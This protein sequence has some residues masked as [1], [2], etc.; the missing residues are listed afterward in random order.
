MALPEPTAVALQLPADVGPPASVRRTVGEIASALKEAN[1]KKVREGLAP[2]PTHLRAVI[3]RAH[4]TRLALL[5]E[6]DKWSRGHAS[7]TGVGFFAVKLD[8]WRF[9]AKNRGYGGYLRCRVKGCSWHLKI[10]QAEDDSICVYD[11]QLV[12]S[13]GGHNPLEATRAEVAATPGFNH[14]PE[15]LRTIAEL[16]H[17]AGCNPRKV[18][19]M[20]DVAAAGSGIIK[21]WD[22]A[23]VYNH[24]RVIDGPKDMDARGLVD[25]LN[26]REKRH[27]LRYDIFTDADNA[28]ERVFF[29]VPGALE[30]QQRNFNVVL[31]DTT[32]GTNGYGL[33]LGCFTG[34]DGEGKTILLAVSLVKFEDTSS[35]AW[36]FRHFSE[37]MVL[38]E[39]ESS[40][41]PD[42]L[43]TDSD[44]AMTAA[45]DHVWPKPT[46]HLLC[47]YHIGQNLKTH[48]VQLFPGAANNAKRREFEELFHG[49]LSRRGTAADAASFESDWREMLQKVD[50][51]T[52]CPWGLPDEFYDACE[53]EELDQCKTAL[54]TSFEDEDRA[55]TIEFE[56]LAKKGR[57][58]AAHLGWLWLQSM[59]RRRE[60]WGKAFV[61]KHFTAGT[62]STQRS[63]SWHAA[64]KDFMSK[65]VRLVHLCQEI[66]AKRQHMT[67][68]SVVEAIR[69]RN[70]LSLS[71][72][73]GGHNKL[74]DGMQSKLTS[75]AFQ[76]LKGLIEK[77]GMYAV[78]VSKFTL[79]GAEGNAMF[80]VAS[81]D[82]ETYH[83]SLRGCGCQAPRN[84]GLPCEHQLAILIC[85]QKWEI[86]GELI[87]ALWRIPTLAEQKERAELLE[88]HRKIFSKSGKKKR[89]CSEVAR[90]QNVLDKA[91]ARQLVFAT[92]RKLADVVE[93][94]PSVLTSVVSGIEELTLQAETAIRLKRGEARR[95]KKAPE[96]VWAR[97]GAP[98][99]TGSADGDDAKVDIPTF[100]VPAEE[101]R[102]PVHVAPPGRM[103]RARKRPG[104]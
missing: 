12:H 48:A 36:A 43:F 35:F 71:R 69:K 101:I 9:Q 104:V 53:D 52:R 74:L 66:E 83:C 42:V 47:S 100:G 81:R 29:E 95:K 89:S 22:Y 27:G 3:S 39:N 44:P 58:T 41:H 57:K 28:I 4:P 37:V 5:A 77:A 88:A 62:F 91:E 98:P 103:Q 68:A 87:H 32:F 26:E 85:E 15:E 14:I 38:G 94:D 34:I 64:L 21:S 46:A 70:R 78:S 10:E 92:V 84:M 67:E 33:K 7:E 31:Y 90:A 80:D 30:W 2:V 51:V 86:P 50:A 61:M 99:A 16:A 8:T 65:T 13:E 73:D 59:Y 1:E 20:L 23:T 82:G 6:V 76:T 18:E 19:R 56:R 49:F 79:G 55:K 40:W 96:M 102:N 63:E 25:W 93:A 17:R 72:D 24:L 11:H 60:R 97:A 75:K 45:A 54:Q